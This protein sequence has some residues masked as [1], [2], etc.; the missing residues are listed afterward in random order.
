MQRRKEFALE[1]LNAITLLGDLVAHISQIQIGPS[2]TRRH[3]RHV[4]TVGFLER[5]LRHAQLS[6]Q[7]LNLLLLQQL[8][9][10]PPSRPG[11]IPGATATAGG[12]NTNT[13]RVV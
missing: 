12:S 1:V 7:A 13:L 2:Q 9:L 10:V 3:Q 4:R 11:A 6:A 8:L 5:L